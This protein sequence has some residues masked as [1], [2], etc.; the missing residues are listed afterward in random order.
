VCTVIAQ[1]AEGQGMQGSAV[2]V[3]PGRLVT[4]NHV[5]AGAAQITVRHGADQY[6]A[7]VATADPEH[8][9]ALLRADALLAP[10]V[11]F[12]NGEDVRVGQS[13]YAIG[14]PRGLE[15][16]LSEGIVSSLRSTADGSV[17]QTTA[18]ISP[19]SSGG[20]LF[21]D[22]GRLIGLTTMQALN[23]QSLNFAIP[24]AWLSKVGVSVTPD[25]ADMP[26]V[27]TPPA[28]AFPP[29]VRARAA[30]T[31][32]PATAVA[33]APTKAAPGKGRLFLVTALILGLLAGAKPAVNWLADAMSNIGTARAAG[34]GTAKAS[35]DRLLPFRKTVREEVAAGKRDAA[36][37]AKALEQ[38]AGDEHRAA[39][40]YV[41]QRAQVLYRADLDRKWAAA[42]AQSSGPIPPRR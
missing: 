15:Q 37:W 28:Q 10:S 19:G 13:V 3:G 21:D 31:A 20:G 16:T 41:E 22:H 1:S 39:E 12:G 40:A 42:K 33:S 2:V 4:N 24:I 11:R 35:V 9:L 36:L 32:L 14:S 27:A 7:Y 5:V 29:P 18:A 23:G 38:A 8:D 34:R 30:D 26:A 6:S 17:I 25:A